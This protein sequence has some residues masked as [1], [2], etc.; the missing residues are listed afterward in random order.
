MNMSFFLRLKSICLNI[1][2]F[3]LFFGCSAQS[4]TV[5]ELDQSDITQLKPVDLLTR[6]RHDHAKWRS[7][8][9]LAHF[10]KVQL[11]ALAGDTHAL[12]IYVK[13]LQQR[14]RRNNIE[15]WQPIILNF[16][17]DIDER[18]DNPDDCYWLAQL[19]LL[20]KRYP[21]AIALLT[22]HS[23]AAHIPSIC[24]LSAILAQTNIMRTAEAA[25]LA[26]LAQTIS[27]TPCA[28]AVDDTHL[29]LRLALATVYPLDQPLSVDELSLFDEYVLFQKN[30][31]PYYRLQFAIALYE[32]DMFDRALPVFEFLAD[33]GNAK[34]AY[35]LGN[36]YHYGF[37]GV[38]DVEKAEHYYQIGIDNEH[39]HSY[40]E[41]AQ[42]YGEF[43]HSYRDLTRRQSYYQTA[44]S[45][46]VLE[47]AKPVIY[48]KC[49]DKPRHDVECQH[50]LKMIGAINQNEGFSYVI[51]YYLSSLDIDGAPNLYQMQ[52]RQAVKLGHPK[53]QLYA[54]LKQ[55]EE[56]QVVIN[57]NNLTT[58]AKYSNGFN[59]QWWY[60][61]LCG[62]D[63][64][65][66]K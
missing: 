29:L 24:A 23:E 59:Q 33:Q 19:Y 27:S 60:W 44:L 56:E 31:T 42:L 2:F 30:P 45:L 15:Y 65:C 34:A 21:E 64:M 5:T 57:K 55:M 4:M 50:V 39:P 52:L 43:S 53:G 10:R 40:F 58:I 22:P 26:H 47:A 9:E 49:H 63:Q 66:S 18:L 6:W 12:E 32:S 17:K 14:V 35:Y 20:V 54:M 3:M 36:I 46:G 1:V 61:K 48:N 13:Y 41:M 25:N 16:L 51:G 38:L 62:W 28:E 37:S 7:K 8:L 11:Q